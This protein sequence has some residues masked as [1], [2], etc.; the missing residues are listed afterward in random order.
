[1]SFPVV[2]VLPGAVLVTLEPE[3]K[4][5]FNSCGATSLIDDCDDHMPGLNRCSHT[6]PANARGQQIL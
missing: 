2:P 1:M 6:P 4:S 5:L 3:E